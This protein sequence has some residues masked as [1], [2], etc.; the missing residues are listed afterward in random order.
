MPGA[1]VRTGLPEADD[2]GEVQPAR[3][4][5]LAHVA[6]DAAGES[7]PVAD[8]ERV[9]FGGEG[10]APG[11]VAGQQPET[12]QGIENRGQ[13]AAGCAGRPH[14]FVKRQALRRQGIEHLV[15]DR[16]LDHQRGGEGPGELQNALRASQAVWHWS[17]KS[18]VCLDWATNQSI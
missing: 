1:S 13:S 2:I 12:D 10:V 5:L 18:P 9:A 3:Q 14:Q 17:W 15:A 6:E 4:Q 11:I 7:R 16:G 8:Q